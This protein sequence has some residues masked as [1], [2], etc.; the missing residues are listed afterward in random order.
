MLPKKKSH[1]INF[2]WMNGETAKDPGW[3]GTQA[4]G[5]PFTGVGKVP[6]NLDEHLTDEAIATMG[7]G[8]NTLGENLL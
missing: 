6:V 5:V 2:L 1:V 4:E 3:F 7:F 8:L